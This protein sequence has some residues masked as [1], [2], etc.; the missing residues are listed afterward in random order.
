MVLCHVLV[1]I[2]VNYQKITMLSTLNGAAHSAWNVLNEKTC[3]GFHMRC[4]TFSL[5]HRQLALIKNNGFMIIAS[6]RSFD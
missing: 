1:H 6:H 4:A 3:E 2:F 5:S